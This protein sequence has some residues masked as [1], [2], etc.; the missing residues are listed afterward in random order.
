[1]NISA[2][3]DIF[4]NRNRLDPLRIDAALG[5][6]ARVRVTLWFAGHTRLPGQRALERQLEM[7]GW[8]LCQIGYEEGLRFVCVE[9]SA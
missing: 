4:M 3:P 7:Q 8:R 1:M 5:E 2:A 6:R 9:R